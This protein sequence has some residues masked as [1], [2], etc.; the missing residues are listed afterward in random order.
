MLAPSPPRADGSDLILALVSEKFA[1]S[2]AVTASRRA[3]A[4]AS[5]PASALE[6]DETSRSAS[7][8]KFISG[9]RIRGSPHPSPPLTKDRVIKWGSEA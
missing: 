8:L 2:L 5:A 3:S 4:P 9:R 6:T 7:G 1:G